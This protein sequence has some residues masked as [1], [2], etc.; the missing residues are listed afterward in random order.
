MEAAVRTAATLAGAETPAGPL[1]EARG[2]D[3]IKCF[4]V[5][6]GD[7]TLNLAVVNG[8]GRVRTL[9]EEGLNDMHFVEVM[10]CPGGCAG[11][12]G[13]PYGTEAADLRKRLD[14]VYDADTRA[15]VRSSHE[16]R[17]VATL[18]EEYLGRPL[19]EVSHRLLHRSYTDRSVVAPTEDDAETCAGIGAGASH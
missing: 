5:D 17:S 9:L 10:S 15:A 1:T 19:G 11:G 8:L 13:Q 16:N 3:G 4:T 14:R 6:V 7:T 12:G 18:Y 2:L